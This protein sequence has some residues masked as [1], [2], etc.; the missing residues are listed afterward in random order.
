MPFAAGGPALP[1]VLR[2][3][4]EARVVGTEVV[5]FLRERPIR[6]GLQETVETSSEGYG[7]AETEGSQG[8]REAGVKRASA[9]TTSVSRNG[10]RLTAKWRL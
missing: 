3:V 8:G 6:E 2:C 10:R 5:E 1:S 7:S 4:L 9:L